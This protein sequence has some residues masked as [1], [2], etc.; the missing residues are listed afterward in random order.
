MKALPHSTLLL[1]TYGRE[2]EVDLPTLNLHLCISL[3]IM[4]FLPEERHGMAFDPCEG[5]CLKTGISIVCMSGKVNS[6]SFL[7]AAICISLLYFC[8]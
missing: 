1:I 2:L 8:I 6:H 5:T 4:D 3:E 7:Q